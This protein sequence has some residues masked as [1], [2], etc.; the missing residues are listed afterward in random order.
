MTEE[1]SPDGSTAS[2]DIEQSAEADGGRRAT[3]LA[4][5]AAGVSIFGFVSLFRLRSGW[6]QSRARSFRRFFG[7]QAE[8]LGGVALGYRALNRL[9]SGSDD[10]RG[11]PFAVV[12]IVLGVSNLV[13]AFL[14]LRQERPE[15]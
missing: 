15:V 4:V 10:Q 14:W 11:V 12:G 1:T 5:F 3:G 8:S 9:R 7:V 2:A 6:D 13:R